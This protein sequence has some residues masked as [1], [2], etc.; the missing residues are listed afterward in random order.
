MF[1]WREEV[2]V[3]NKEVGCC[4]DGVATPWS[5]ASAVPAGRLRTYLLFTLLN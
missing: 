1:S 3:V 2:T 4:V 5:D